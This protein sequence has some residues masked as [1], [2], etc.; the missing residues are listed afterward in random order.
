MNNCLDVIVAGSSSSGK[1][2]FLYDLKLLL[3]LN[4]FDVEIIFDKNSD[5]DNI[6][7]FSKSMQKNYDE[8]VKL[9]KKNVKIKLHESNL[10]VSTL[11]K[12]LN[13]NT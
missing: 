4:G 10:K 6:K 13:E 12:T 1:S 7:D 8:R 2:T 3:G 11:N 9:L 5:Y